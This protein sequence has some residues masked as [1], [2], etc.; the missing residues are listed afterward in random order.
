ALPCGPRAPGRIPACAPPRQYRAFENDQSRTSVLECHV[1]TLPARRVRGADQVASWFPDSSLPWLPSCSWPERP[2][3]RARSPPAP[4]TSSVVSPPL[5]A[6]LR[7]DVDTM[8]PDTTL[9]E[10][11]GQHRLGNREKAACA[12]TSRWSS[13]TSWCSTH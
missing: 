6:A 11:F 12:P 1:A 13:S 8:P 5:T 9:N 7:T 4:G 2:P 3:P 10:F